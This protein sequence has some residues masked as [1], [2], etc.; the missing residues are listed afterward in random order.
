MISNINIVD[1]QITFNILTDESNST[2]ITFENLESIDGTQALVNTITINQ[3]DIP[4]NPIWVTNQPINETTMY[5]DIQ[6]G[7][8]EDIL[9]VGSITTS[10]LENI[11]INGYSGGTI[12]FDYTTTND[13]DI[14]FTFTDIQT[15]NGGIDTLT[16]KVFADLSVNRLNHTNDEYSRYLNGQLRLEYTGNNDEYTEF[17][18]LVPGNEQQNTLIDSY[19][20]DNVHF[21]EHILFLDNGELRID[22]IIIATVV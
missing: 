8:N 10:L 2:E 15:V 6:V 12:H 17:M 14:E 9:S 7:F 21:D 13:T 16:L 18:N 22:D 1:D 19:F 11:V 5:M 20:I 4:I 3:G